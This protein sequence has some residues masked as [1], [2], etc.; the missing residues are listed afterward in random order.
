[1]TANQTEFEKDRQFLEVLYRGYTSI[2]YV[3]FSKI[4]RS[5]LK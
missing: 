5:L 3:D 1:M 2:Y 4:L